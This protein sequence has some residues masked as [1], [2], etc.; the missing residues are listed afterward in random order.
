MGGQA[1]AHGELDG[2]LVQHRQYAGKAGAYRASV[3]IGL[4]AEPGRATAKDL[5]LGEHLGVD[6]EAYDGLVFHEI[7]QRREET[8]RFLP[9]ISVYDDCALS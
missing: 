4:A 3:G 2:A 8:A 7:R 6:F 1:G 5:R 9:P